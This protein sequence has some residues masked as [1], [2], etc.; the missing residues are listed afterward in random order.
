MPSV[1]GDKMDNQKR[2]NFIYSNSVAAHPC[3]WTGSSLSRQRFKHN[4]HTYRYEYR[5]LKEREK[6]R[7]V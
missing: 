4:T 1:G 6:P 5:R 3:H 2:K 7:G